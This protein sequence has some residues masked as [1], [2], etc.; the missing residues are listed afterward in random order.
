M[1]QEAQGR[2]PRCRTPLTEGARFCAQCGAR[3]SGQEEQPVLRV[4]LGLGSAVAAVLLGLFGACSLIT[5]VGSLTSG[6]A[7]AGFGLLLLLLA[8]AAIAGVV[9]LAR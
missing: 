6:G 5:G 1:S 9:K 8:A 2:C 3:V 4:L 7:G